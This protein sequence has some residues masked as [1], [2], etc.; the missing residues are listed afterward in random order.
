[1][2]DK[3]MLLIEVEYETDYTYCDEE[4]KGEHQEGFVTL[5]CT[6]D[7]YYNTYDLE[8]LCKRVASYH[9]DDDNEISNLVYYDRDSGFID[10][11]E[12]RQV[13]ID[14]IELK[15]G[16]FISSGDYCGLI[17][18]YENHTSHEETITE[19]FIIE[20]DK[21]PLYHELLAHDTTPSLFEDKNDICTE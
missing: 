7:D 16:S 10:D 20:L 18:D 8:E 3:N 19:D 1:M 2:N 17:C 21:H 11:K 12:L 14:M 6:E 5:Y 4:D 9:L 15:M 13:C